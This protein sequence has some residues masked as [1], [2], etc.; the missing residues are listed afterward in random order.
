[1]WFRNLIVFRVPAVWDISADAL[2][3]QLQTLAFTPGMALEE[4]SIGWVPPRDGDASLVV[5]V[6]RQML[7]ALRQEKKLLPP[8]VI[9]QVLKERVERI[10][11]EEGFKPGRKR[12]KELRDA[13]RDELLPRAF[14]LS[15]DMRAWIDPVN[16]WF[17]IDAASAKRAEDLMTLLLKAV[18]GMPVRP[19]RVG[20]SVAG[21]M[22]AWLVTGD[23]PAGFT[24]D[25]DVEL[26]A[27]DGKATVRYAN[28]SIE[29]DEV[30][31]HTRNG[32][33]CS[34]LALTWNSRVS[35]VLTDKLEI[36][37]VR[38]LD[39]IKEAAASGD[40]ADADARFAS[41]FT[42]MSG[43]LGR[44]LQDVVDA[45]GGEQAASGEDAGKAVPRTE[46]LAPLAK[47][48]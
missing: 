29:L 47:A 1:M 11:A 42:M 21:E 3:L 39:V 20:A 41:D 14:S 27:R 5:S 19:L 16:G 17:V 7:I 33:Q 45:L 2:A 9:A 24:V 4:A 40:D 8:K 13:V 6:G 15:T 25:Q 32:K 18:D 43:E 48:A 12:M 46:E 44:M 23:A 34:R 26:R 28:Q 37:R 35:L 36:K 31:R 10:E 30:T 22:T 38:P